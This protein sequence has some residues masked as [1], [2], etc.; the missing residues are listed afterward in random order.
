MTESVK[1]PE[2]SCV[3]RKLSLWHFAIGAAL[4]NPK[5]REKLL[6][7]TTDDSS[8]GEVAPLVEAIR[9][10]D[11]AGVWSAL[12]AYWVTQEGQETAIDAILRKLEGDAW[13][14]S[15]STTYNNVIRDLG[16]EKDAQPAI[17]ALT[18]L[19]SKYKGQAPVP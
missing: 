19:L 16:N 14:N 9:V 18:E 17:N 1:M 7:L 11:G 12:N 4:V 3:Y 10:G 6:A 8:L 5:Y 13:K 15:V 2:A